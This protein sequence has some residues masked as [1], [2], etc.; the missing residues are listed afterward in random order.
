MLSMFFMV[1]QVSLFNWTGFILIMMLLFAGVSWFVYW[2]WSSWIKSW[3]F[4]W[5][6]CVIAWHHQYGGNGLKNFTDKN[7][8]KYRVVEVADGGR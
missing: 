2:V 3:G 4:M 7:G 5:R 8:K 6:V 1:W